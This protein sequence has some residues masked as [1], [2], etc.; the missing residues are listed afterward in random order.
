MAAKDELV[1]KCGSILKHLYFKHQNIIFTKTNL[2]DD[3]EVGDILI[4]AW[5]DGDDSL[6]F[7]EYLIVIHF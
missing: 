6:S 1:S 3:F 5:S 7:F 4:S 2:T